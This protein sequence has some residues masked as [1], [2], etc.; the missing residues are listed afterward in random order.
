MHTGGT[1]TVQNC[2]FVGTYASTQVTNSLLF[3]VIQGTSNI[4][5]ANNVFNASYTLSSNG[6]SLVAS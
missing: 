6:S 1:T 5:M 3:Y 4:I 2:S